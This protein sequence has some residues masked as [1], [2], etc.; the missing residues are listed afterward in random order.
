MYNRQMTVFNPYFGIPP[1]QIGGSAIPLNEQIYYSGLRRQRGAGA[2]TS[3]FS[4]L[5]RKLLPLSKQYVL[6]HV[7]TAARQVIGDELQGENLK[8]SVKKHGKV[9][10]KSMGNEILTQS[11]KGRYRRR[12]RKRRSVR[13]IKTT[14]KVKRGGKRKKK[15]LGLKKSIFD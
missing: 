5:A 13:K 9:A 7:K 15:F 3:F 8:D 11:G 14:R 6:P 10:L 2:L 12:V 1:H 4:S